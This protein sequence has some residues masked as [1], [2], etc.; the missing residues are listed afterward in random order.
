M[1]ETPTC[2]EINV[3]GYLLAPLQDRREIGNAQT[4]WA[5]LRVIRHR[6]RV[7]ELLVHRRLHPRR[8]DDSF[9][10][11]AHVG[12]EYMSFQRF[13]RSRPK[14]G[15]E[16]VAEGG[17]QTFYMREARTVRD[18]SRAPLEVPLHTTMWGLKLRTYM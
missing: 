13:L 3:A 14:D 2:G 17:G 5:H 4:Q 8:Y 9:R 7:P 1:T 11:N 6:V 15:R 12:R 16:V 10:L 18:P